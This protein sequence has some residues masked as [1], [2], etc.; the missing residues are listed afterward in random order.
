MTGEVLQENANL[1][2]VT[3]AVRGPETLKMAYKIK[4]KSFLSH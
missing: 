3:V 2:R 1:S 4:I